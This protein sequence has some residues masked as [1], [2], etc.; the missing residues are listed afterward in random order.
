MYAPPHIIKPTPRH[1]GSAKGKGSHLGGTA[2][3][4]SGLA[5][6]HP[7]RQDLADGTPLL[8]CRAARGPALLTKAHLCS[9]FCATT[10]PPKTHW[11]AFSFLFYQQIRILRSSE[12]VPQFGLLEN[13]TCPKTMCQI[14]VKSRSVPRL[15]NWLG[16]SLNLYYWSNV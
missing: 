5:P 1:L 7:P 2:A 10:P 14:L 13:G 9:W 11:P 3:S 8:P 4:T 12:T 16:R 6:V 15:A